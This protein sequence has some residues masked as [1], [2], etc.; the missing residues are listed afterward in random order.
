[1]VYAT[2]SAPVNAPLE[3]LWNL[4]IDKIEN[5]QKYVPGISQVNILAKDNDHVLR[6]MTIP[7]GIIKEKITY[8]VNT[9]EVVFTLV[10]NPNF[11]GTVINKI[12][13]SQ[14]KNEPITLEFTL[15]WQLINFDSLSSESDMSETIKQAVLHTKQLAEQQTN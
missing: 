13:I 8:N 6:E 3:V 7:T 5:P 14:V 10:D 9:K 15:N 11:S 4:L 12:H 1:M 2:F